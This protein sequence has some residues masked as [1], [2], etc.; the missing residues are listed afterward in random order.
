MKELD[1][2]KTILNL[3][4]DHSNGYFKTVKDDFSKSNNEN[5]IEELAYK[6]FIYL[7]NKSYDNNNNNNNINI[8]NNIIL[9]KFQ[10]TNKIKGIF[11]GIFTGEKN[12]KSIADSFSKVIQKYIDREN[13]I[14]Q[15]KM[16]LENQEFIKKTNEENLIKINNKIVEIN[17]KIKNMKKK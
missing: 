2:Q 4:K 9:N 6:T 1:F 17:N 16:K 13:K 10:N 11:T 8:E 14:K 15:I 12:R 7:K 3:K 5:E